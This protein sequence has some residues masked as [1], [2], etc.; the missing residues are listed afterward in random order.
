[1]LLN[2]FNLDISY[3][4]RSNKS[5]DYKM[6]R[7]FFAYVSPYECGK[8]SR[9][10]AVNMSWLVILLYLHYATYVDECRFIAWDV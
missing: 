6:D 3:T 1:M 9:C 10:T 5:V 8:M 4:R 2:W 7:Y